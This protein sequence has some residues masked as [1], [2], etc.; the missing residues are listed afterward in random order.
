LQLDLTIE[1]VLDE[2]FVLIL[3]FIEVD[4]EGQREHQADEQ[5]DEDE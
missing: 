1:S 3:I 4:Q 2:R 5:D